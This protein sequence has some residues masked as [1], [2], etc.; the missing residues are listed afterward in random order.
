MVSCPCARRRARQRARIGQSRAVLGVTRFGHK[1]TTN[2][3]D[4]LFHLP[5]PSPFLSPLRATFRTP[6][7]PPYP[8]TTTT[9]ASTTTAINDDANDEYT[10]D[11][12]H[13][14]VGHP[15]LPP[16]SL[17]RGQ[18]HLRHHDA[19]VETTTVGHE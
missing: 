19:T 9:M 5:P 1:S 12:R 6:P 11:E 3:V 10:A 17:P 4:F 18:H 15:P 14:V 16:P 8:T 7:P 13:S 2:V